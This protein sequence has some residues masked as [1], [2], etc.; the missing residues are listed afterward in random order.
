MEVE[1]VEKL[2]MNRKEWKEMIQNRIKFLQSFDEQ[3]GKKYEKK[4]GKVDIVE[5]SQEKKED[6]IRC[7]FQGCGRFFR[8]KSG[9]TITKREH[10]GRSMKHLLL[11]ATNVGKISNRKGHGKTIKEIAQEVEWKERKKSAT[12]A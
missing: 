10:T 11:L 7:I 4:P 1:S 9:L 5:R 12:Y 6:Q 3:K 8:K 2:V